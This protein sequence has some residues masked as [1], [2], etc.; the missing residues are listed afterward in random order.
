MN[1]KRITE[2]IFAV[3]LLFGGIMG[4]IKGLFPNMYWL[5]IMA[6]ILSFFSYMGIMYKISAKFY[7]AYINAICI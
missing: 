2:R 4:T 1:E 5:N 7:F 3:V 6:N